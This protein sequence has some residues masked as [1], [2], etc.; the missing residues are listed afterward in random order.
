MNFYSQY[1]QDKFLYNN[2]FNKKRN[3]VFIDI[4]AHDG[5]TFSNSYFF[6]KELNWKGICIEPIYEVFEELNK[7]RKCILENCAIYNVEGELDFVRI[8]GNGEMLSGFN[9]EKIAKECCCDDTYEIIKVPTF[10]LNTILKKYNIKY[11]DLCS[12]DTEGTEVEVI[13]SIDF[14]NVYID[15]FCIESNNRID[16]IDLVLN[17]YYK[18][19]HNICGDVFYRRKYEVD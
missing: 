1:R 10:N 3:G 16:E 14:S 2:I 5:I 9:R 18:Q 8:R 7:N 4:G 12:I 13:K 19:I 15:V 6:E 11:A 17:K